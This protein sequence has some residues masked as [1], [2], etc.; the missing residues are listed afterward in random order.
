M[1]IFAC[2]ANGDDVFQPNFVCNFHSSLKNPC[3]DSNDDTA[4]CESPYGYKNHVAL[5]T[6]T[7]EFQV[8]LSRLCKIYSLF[9]FFF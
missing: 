7:K 8:R 9:L 2:G 1:S 5:S 6:D 4:V 3:A